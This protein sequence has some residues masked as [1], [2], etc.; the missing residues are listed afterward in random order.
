MLLYVREGGGGR[1][2]GEGASITY[3]K[4][5]GKISRN[6]MRGRR[7]EDETRDGEPERER[8]VPIP[9]ACAVG[10]PGEQERDGD[11]EEPGRDG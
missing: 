6:L 9:F 10:V 4:H 7:G 5:H 3:H 2:G 11:S 1:T 8:D